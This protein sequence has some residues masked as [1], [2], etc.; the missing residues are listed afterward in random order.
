MA[1]GRVLA[2]RPHAAAP[3]GVA[4]GHTARLAARA[5]PQ[6]VE[7]RRLEAAE[8]EVVGTLQPGSGQ[9]HGRSVALPGQTLQVWSARI[10]EP[11]QPRHLVEGF[12]RRIITGTAQQ[13]HAAVTFHVDQ[14]SMAA[15]NHQA[16]QGE[17]GRIVPQEV[18]ID[19][20]WRWFTP[21]RG[22]SSA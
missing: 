20:P 4:L 11:Q 22:I 16:H 15:G 6:E 14:V 17:F 1:L 12:A 18:G 5:A 13:C 7:H 3:F 2:N 8:A 21:T 10:R 19:V 9:R